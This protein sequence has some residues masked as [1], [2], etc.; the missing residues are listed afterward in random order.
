MA[1][2]MLDENLNDVSRRIM[3]VCFIASP[4]G[5][6]TKNITVLQI[7]LTNISMK[8]LQDAVNVR[9]PDQ[10]GRVIDLLRFPPTL[11]Q[12]FGLD[13]ILSLTNFHMRCMVSIRSAG[14]INTHVVA[15]EAEDS[16]NHV[17]TL[18]YQY[19]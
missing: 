15:H 19:R 17:S 18:E 6:V 4:D 5:T 8:N 16:P 2:S 1:M 14:L 12:H 9:E 7:K 3:D 13:L 10:I 11:L